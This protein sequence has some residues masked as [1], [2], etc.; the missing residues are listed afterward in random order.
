MSYK[1]FDRTPDED[2]AKS[3]SRNRRIGLA[4]LSSVGSKATT[5]GLQLLAIPVGVSALGLERFGVFATLTALLAWITICQIGIGPALTLDIAAG[6]A[7][8]DRS[9]ERKYF[10]TALFSMF[11]VALAILI[12]FLFLPHVISVPD[13]L[14]RDYENFLPEIRT[15]MIVLAI[16]L[17]TQMI[18][19]VTEAART[20]YQE[21]HITNLCNMI[22][23]GA[24]CI[25]VLVVASAWPKVAGLIFAVYSGPVIAGTL[26]SVWLVGWSRPYLWPDVRRFDRTYAGKLIRAGSAFALIQISVFLSRELS[27]VILGRIDGPASVAEMSIMFRMVFFAQGIIIM[28]SQPWW[29]AIMEAASRNDFGWIR[30]SY[31]NMLYLSLFYAAGICIVFIAGTDFLVSKWI[32]KDIVTTP[33]LPFFI[34]VY[35]VLVAWNNLHYTL[36]TGLG[37]IRQCA[38]VMVIEGILICSL[39]LILVPL[40]HTLG[41]ALALCLGMICVSMWILPWLARRGLSHLES[42]RE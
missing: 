35:F 17:A 33:Y 32:G 40:F 34:R 21:V 7:H 26:N 29:P 15:G 27:L 37:M 16:L 39:C 38:F 5:M 9:A 11:L 2:E 13:L 8:T 10:S 4:V 18:L 22:G 25:L 31:R 42:S 24:S 1:L 3:R 23:N 19:S 6:A 12:I 30:T 36:T 14:G 41:V 20:G 28:I